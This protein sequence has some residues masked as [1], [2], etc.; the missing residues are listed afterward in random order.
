MALHFPGNTGFQYPWHTPDFRYDSGL[1][2]GRVAWSIWVKPDDVSYSQELIAIVD[3]ATFGAAPGAVLSCLRLEFGG[4]L[5]VLFQ[6]SAFGF[7]NVRR[8]AG[9]LS[10]GTW[11]HIFV[12]APSGFGSLDVYLDGAVPTYAF[13]RLDPGGLPM[14][15]GGAILFGTPFRG[16]DDATTGPHYP[17][18]IRLVNGDPGNG[19]LAKRFTTTP[20][21][22]FKGA[23]ACAGF[24][25]TGTPFFA[26]AEFAESLAAGTS[27][28]FLAQKIEDSSVSHGLLFVPPLV[29]EDPAMDYDPVSDS[30]PVDSF[31]ATTRFGE[32]VLGLGALTWEEGPGIIEPCEPDI[33]GPAPPVLGIPKLCL[34]FGLPRAGLYPN[35]G[36]PGD[37]LPIVYG[38]FRL[39]GL[40]GP[41]PAILIDR[42]AIPTDDPTVVAG[43]WTFC[44]AFHAVVSLDTVYIDDVPQ[45]PITYDPLTPTLGTATWGTVRLSDSFGGRGIIATITFTEQPVGPVSWRG[46][47]LYDA[48]GLVVM[49]NAIDQF[50][51]LLTT[52]GNFERGVDFD[53]GSL[54]ESRAAVT[55]MGYLTAFVVRD[56]SVTQEWLTEM[57]FN[58]MGYWRINGREQIEIHIDTGS[59]PTIAELGAAVLASRD[60]IDGDD[61]VE[62]VLDRQDL[63]NQLNAYYLFSWS[64]GAP[65]SVIVTEEDP[66]SIEA[67]GPVRKAVTLKGLRRDQDVRTWCQILFARQSMRTRVEGAMVRFTV[68]GSRFTHLTIGDLIAFSWPYGPVRE[69]GN[70][71]MNE[72]L[73]IGDITL[74][75]TRGGAQ[76]IIAVDLGNYVT[77]AGGTRL[78]TPLAL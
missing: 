71:Y 65:S 8:V 64:T 43:P 55:S 22:W 17:A 44:A 68:H 51:H 36:N 16:L 77:G 30:L 5:V 76:T 2:G 69:N 20:G 67:Y 21:T 58:V 40:R 15:G 63:V 61:G 7:V 26:P 45:A 14:G 47:G 12:I 4:D 46:Q 57:L 18:G 75:T 72:I 66:T 11:T 49:E 48:D 3:R 56:E 23:M 70:L 33:Y 24:W 37:I 59:P 54:A 6:S 39:G 34:P 27:P 19:D 29:G 60:V 9:A 31:Q 52:F 35:P 10:V 32:T 42:G 50:V 74:D 38:D 53:E 28:L 78:L 1:T 25:H 41:V 62:W 13:S 73:R